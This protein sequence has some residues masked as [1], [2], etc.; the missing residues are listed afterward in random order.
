MSSMSDRE[1]AAEEHKLK[2]KPIDTHVEWMRLAELEACRSEN[3][4]KKRETQWRKWKE[5]Q[6]I[7][8]ETVGGDS[9]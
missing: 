4:K 3:M 6:V 1:K 8:K 7:E 2:R 5:W 9:Q